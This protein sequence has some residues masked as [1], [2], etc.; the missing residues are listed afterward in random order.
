[1]TLSGTPPTTA[2]VGK[3]YEFV[4]AASNAITSSLEFS[5][6]NRPSW[7][8]S[9]RSS[10]A[11][12]GTPTAPG[13]YGDIVI[14]AWDGVH[15]AT[16][17]PF[18]ITV[19]A[20][21]GSSTKLEISGSPATSAAVGKYYSFTPTVVAPAGSSLTYKITNL[22]AWAQF[23]AKTGTL[24]GTPASGNASEAGI[25]ISVSDGSQSAS[26]PAFALTVGATSA[27]AVSLTAGPTSVSKG[28]SAMLNWSASNASSCAAS[29]GWS[30]SVATSG[31]KSTGALNSSTSYTLNC[32]GSG[33]S[34]SKTAVVSVTSST[35]SA[36]QVSRPSYNTGNG[37]FVYNG[38]LYDANGNEFRIRGVDRDHFDSDSQAGIAKSGA[39]A[40]R[41]FVE[42]NYGASVADLVNVVQTQH[43]D[44]KEVPIP[45]A[46]ITTGGTLTSC[47]S[48]TTVFNAV[49]SNWV[50]TASQWK[51]LNKYM[52]LNIANEWGPA[53]STVW[54]NSY[55]SAIASLRA[56]GYLGTLLIDT[57]GCGQDPEDLLNYASAVFNSDPQKNVMFA[58]HFYGLASGY[59]TTAQ[60]NTIFAELAGLRSQGI[61][62]AI[63]EFGPGRDIGPSPTMVTP[64]EVIAAAEANQ[65]GWAAW[66]WDDNDLA[67]CKSDNGWF[68][69]TYNCG[70]YEQTSDL[71]EYGQQV[72]LNS[73]YGLSVLAKPASIFT[74]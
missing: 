4:P 29:G 5:Y 60:M 61:V 50:A 13:V 38:Q 44:E 58:F 64:L 23:S 48:S 16:L 19:K 3:S 49:V 1:M 63:T 26:L 66:A 57:G 18:T 67:D 45:T 55:T 24:S 62:V 8:G 2:T 27:P 68:S 9:Y 17:P 22:P 28:S 31:S 11:I 30:G 39:N 14:Q 32:T 72:V 34:V 56:A 74:D 25:V 36:G 21:A 35:A 33:T 53:N 73:T 46:A 43:I 65:L 70:V 42:T 69:M 40:V 54:R 51:T 6:V 15:W 52:I 71:T 41:L 12:M 7:S 10:G 59:S 37:F 20:A 47:S